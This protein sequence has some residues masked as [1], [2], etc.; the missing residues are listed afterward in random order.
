MNEYFKRLLLGRLG[1]A[2]RNRS[3]AAV[4]AS[5]AAACWLGPA[6]LPFSLGLAAL[7][8][9]RYLLSPLCL[10]VWLLPGPCGPEALLS[11]AFLSLVVSGFRTL[12]IENQKLA[13]TRQ[14]LLKTLVHEL[15]NPLFAAK[16]T[17]DNLAAR[18]HELKPEE[19]DLQLEM[20]SSAMQT[21]NQEVDDLTQLLRLESN[22]LIARPNVVNLKSIYKN[23][24]RRHPED[25][26]PDHRLVFEG[27][28]FVLTCDPLLLMQAIDKLITNAFV[29]APGGLVLVRARECGQRVFIEVQDEGPG[30]TAEQRE[31]VFDRFKQL[32]GNSIGFGLGLYLARQY[33]RAQNGV[34][35]LEES[36]AGCLFRI[37]LPKASDENQDSY[38]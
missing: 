2:E 37:S 25:Q 18:F 12:V 30:I 36:T 17:I 19:L 33:V 34:L 5:S 13:R 3:T 1:A 7:V 27:S 38:S 15:R 10:A 23:L 6:L 26:H 29:H 16:G 32:G 21:I 22:R 9:R 8:S 31:S 11:G 35:T 24:S 28:E 14:D 20:A 4:L